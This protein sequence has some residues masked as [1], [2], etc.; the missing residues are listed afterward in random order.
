MSRLWV[1][2]RPSL[3]TGFHLAGV[4]AYGAEDIETIEELITAWLDDGETGLLAIED[5]LVANTNRA[6]IRRLDASSNQ[7]YVTISGDESEG[8]IATRSAR[9]AGM[10]RRAVGV[11]LT[12]EREKNEVT[13]GK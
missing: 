11:H 7:F 3:V 4:E 5:N 1:V 6:I 2:L 8:Q 13:G 12:F 9:I 10:I